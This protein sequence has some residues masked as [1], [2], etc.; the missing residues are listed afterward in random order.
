MCNEG[1][2]RLPY[3][4]VVGLIVSERGVLCVHFQQPSEAAF[5][6]CFLRN[7]EWEKGLLTT[8]S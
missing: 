3:D 7:T 5:A 4:A 2:T 8:D 6:R 1:R